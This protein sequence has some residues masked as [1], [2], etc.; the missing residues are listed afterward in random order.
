MGLKRKLLRSAAIVPACAVAATLVGQTGV[1]NAASRG[2]HVS[3]ESS[4]ALTLVGASHVPTVLCNG[5]ICVP[6]DFPMDFEG[7]PK[8]G[9]VLEPGGPAQAWELKYGFGHTYAAVLKYKIGGTDG[10]FE[11]TIETSTFSN[12]SACK[13]TPASAG[14]CTAVGLKIAFKNH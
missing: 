7:R 5:S 6:T 13:V 4:H 10:T 12:N 3:N 1:A 14:S 9:D 11:A 2:Y 8:D